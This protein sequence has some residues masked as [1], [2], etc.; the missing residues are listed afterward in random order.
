MLSHLDPW[1][2]RD[3]TRVIKWRVATR[4]SRLVLAAACSVFATGTFIGKAQASPTFS[5][6]SVAYNQV[7]DTIGNGPVLGVRNLYPY[8]KGFGHAHPSYLFNGGSTEGVASHIVWRNWG[9]PRTYAS[10]TGYERHR[11]VAAMR[12]RSSCVP[13]ALDPVQESGGIRVCSFA[14][15]TRPVE[16]D[17]ISGRG[18]AISAAARDGLI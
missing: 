1:F 15:F 13:R 18:T 16:A 4:V 10:A 14:R 3:V 5:S 11:K 9:S 8:S 12:C 2:H 6:A 7:R 17:G